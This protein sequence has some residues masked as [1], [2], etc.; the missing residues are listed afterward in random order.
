MEEVWRDIYFEQDGVI[1]DFRGLYQVSN[2]GG[3]IKSLNY[4]QTGKEKIV[5]YLL[6]CVKTENK[7]IFL[8]ID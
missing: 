3:K 4:H 2:I 5:I 6:F 1:W 7:K 8:F